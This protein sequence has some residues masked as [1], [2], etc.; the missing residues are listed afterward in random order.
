[1]NLDTDYLR[2]WIGRAEEASDVVTAHPLAGLSA[3]LDR[4]DPRPQP[5]DPMPP[6]AHW[7]Y[8]LPATRQSE[9][10]ED[11][12]ARLGGFLPP[13]P[14]P[15]RMWA[16]GRIEFRGPLRVGEA[17]RRHSRVADVSAKEGRGE[18]MIFVVV[19]HEVSGPGG[20]AVV[21]DHDIVYREAPRPGAA[22]PPPRPA[23]G[24]AVWQR[25][26]VP[27]SV[28]LFRYS[29]L[30]FNAHRIHYDH[31]YVTGIAGY[32]GLLVHGPLTATLLLDLVRRERPDARVTHFDYRAVRPL[33]DT[34]PFTVAGEPAA[35][36]AS[37]K[38]WALDPEG[39]LAMTATVRLTA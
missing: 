16:G 19:R 39:A 15:R 36:G 29:A 33:Y 9:L 13:V 37:A 32:P 1:M 24:E 20:L 2:Q 23:P 38:L 18:S 21:E 35:D 8:F 5:G 34:A 6:G 11:G 25:T 17:I 26:V 14:L 28:M 27:D 10:G 3:T 7:L 12:H 30:L 31:R 22:P 4:D